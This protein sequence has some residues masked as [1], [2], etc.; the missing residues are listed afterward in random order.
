MSWRV[1]PF[2]SADHEGQESGALIPSVGTYCGLS[3]DS[4]YSVRCGLLS[5]N[6][7]EN[8]TRKTLLWKS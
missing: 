2:C 6:E 8:F 4:C 3:E 7:A 1:Q 5:L